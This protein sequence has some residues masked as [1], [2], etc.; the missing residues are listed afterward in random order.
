MS[1]HSR[2]DVDV[3]FQ[4]EGVG[5]T[6][7][8]KDGAMVVAFERWDAGLDAAEMFKDLP[9]GACWEEHWGYVLKGSGTIRYTDGTEETIT[10]GQAYYLKPGHVP[11]V[12]DD[13]PLE[14]LE[15]TPAD[16]SPDQKPPD[17]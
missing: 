14:L 1:A 2:E 4:Q 17:A 9:D 16:Q 8:T 3:D 5:E 15:F 12:G 6:R 10:E 7:K 13:G 11:R